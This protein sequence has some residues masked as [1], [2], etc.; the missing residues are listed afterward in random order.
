MEKK[1]YNRI[2]FNI[3]FFKTE[4]K[5]KKTTERK[6]KEKWHKYLSKIW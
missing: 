3:V 2:I 1:S 4:E 6:K 5:G